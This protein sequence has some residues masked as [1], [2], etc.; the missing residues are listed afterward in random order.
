MQLP[1]PN[2]NGDYRDSCAVCVRG[3]DT[4]LA[5]TGEAE[6]LEAGLGVLGIPDDEAQH[7]IEAF[8]VEK[9]ADPGMVLTGD[10]EMVV[11]VCAECVAKAP[12]QFPAPCIPA[13]GVPVIGQARTYDHRR[14]S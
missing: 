8:F 5:F 7:M 12:A 11:R 13:F 4:A 9:G 2:L 3:T 14:V 1:P 10:H 6:W